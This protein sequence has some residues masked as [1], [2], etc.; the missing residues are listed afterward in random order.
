[1]TAFISECARGRVLPGRSCRGDPW[2]SPGRDRVPLTGRNKGHLE[3]STSLDNGGP[4]KEGDAKAISL[5][6][7]F[8][9][10]DSKSAPRRGL[11]AHS[12][13]LSLSQNGLRQI[14]HD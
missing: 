4:L 5:R 14:F 2:W 1:M 8:P 6:D 3:S 13:E 7:G 11:K 9:S 10:P 12:G